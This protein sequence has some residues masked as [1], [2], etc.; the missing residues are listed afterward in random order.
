MTKANQDIRE[1]LKAK[2]IP[3]WRLGD[4]LG[5]TE[6]TVIRKLRHELPAEEKERILKVIAEMGDK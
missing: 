6:M 2:K 3:L 1:A 4:A 5:V